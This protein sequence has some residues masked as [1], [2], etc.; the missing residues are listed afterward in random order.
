[1]SDQKFQSLTDKKEFWNNKPADLKVGSELIGKVLL[2]EEARNAKASRT[3]TIEQADG[4]QIGLWL[5]TVIDGAFK[6][7]VH[8]GDTIRVVFN[9][10]ATTKD[11]KNEFNDYSVEV[12]RA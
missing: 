12:A 8:E 5:S 2:I 1:M 3:A 10:K 9:G 4:T 11:G 7:G 6:T